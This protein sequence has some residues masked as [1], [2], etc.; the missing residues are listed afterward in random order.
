MGI[1]G[2]FASCSL[3][4][5]LCLILCLRLSPETTKR[6]DRARELERLL[7]ENAVHFQ[8]ARSTALFYQVEGR[9]TSCLASVTEWRLLEGIHTKRSTAFKK[10]LNWSAS[11]SDDLVLL[12]TAISK[13]EIFVLVLLIKAISKWAIFNQTKS[14]SWERRFRSV[15]FSTKPRAVP[16]EGDFQMWDFRP[17]QE[18]VYE[19]RIKICHSKKRFDNPKRLLKWAG[20]SIRCFQPNQEQLYE[21][22]I[23]IWHSKKRFEN[24]KRLLK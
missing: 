13:W 17:N 24:S 23:K 12:I 10:I 14:S 9:S 4:I 11:W 3:Y 2:V 5:V 21:L 22:R 15:R 16:G 20:R 7:S 1:L 6:G 19:L 8:C 18:Q